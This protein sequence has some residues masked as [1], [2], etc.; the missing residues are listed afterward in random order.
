MNYNDPFGLSPKAILKDAAGVAHVI[1]NAFSCIPGPFGVVYGAMNAGLY[2]LEDDTE[3]AVRCAGQALVTLFA[4]KFGSTIIGGLGNISKQAQLI[5]SIAMIGIGSVQMYQNYK[6]LKANADAYFDELS[7]V[8]LNLRGE[9]I[10][11]QI[12]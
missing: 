4:G 9:V 8:R 6:G 7:I 5:G 10:Q 3:A 1:L 11:M 12:L 2:L